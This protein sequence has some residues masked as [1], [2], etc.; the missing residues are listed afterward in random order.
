MC[1]RVGG[2][3]KETVKY[4]REF[5]WTWTRE[6]L[7]WQDP[8]AI[9]RVNYRPI[10]SS[11]RSP[12][13]KKPAVFRQEKNCCGLQMGA[14]HQNRLADWPVVVTLISGAYRHRHWVTAES[15]ASGEIVTHL[16]RTPISKHRRVCKNENIET[17]IDCAGDDQQQY[18]DLIQKEN[19]IHWK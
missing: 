8:E 17:S 13:I 18:T 10:L 15:V 19:M 2:V 9:E 5:C 3:S 4:G 6:S 12:H 16:T 7:L 11:M 1:H 14:W